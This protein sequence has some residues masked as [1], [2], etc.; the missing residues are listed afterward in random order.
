MS[1]FVRLQSKAYALADELRKGLRLRGIDPT[2]LRNVVEEN[3]KKKIKR[4]NPPQEQA[5]L[6]GMSRNAERW[7]TDLG[8]RVAPAGQYLPLKHLVA[9]FLEEVTGETEEVPS[10]NTPQI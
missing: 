1:P 4:S 2:R 7:V 10:C 3:P 6:E 9:K 8:V 5:L